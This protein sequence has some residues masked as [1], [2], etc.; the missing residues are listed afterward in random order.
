MKL[1]HRLTTIAA[2]ITTSAAA[3]TGT[4]A[5]A[6]DEAP[7]PVVNF[8]TTPN[9]PVTNNSGLSWEELTPGMEVIMDGGNC[10]AGFFAEDAETAE[11]VMI[12]AGHCAD[13]G[14][15]V[16]S[17]K[18]P[19]GLQKT[20]GTASAFTIP[21]DISS[22]GRLRDYATVPLDGSNRSVSPRIANAYDVVMVLK[23]EDLKEGMEL[24][25]FGTRTQETCG[26]FINLDQGFIYSTNFNKPGDSGGPVYVKLGGN[27]VALVG[28]VARGDDMGQLYTTPAANI[29]EHE[30]LLLNGEYGYLPEAGL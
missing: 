25:K 1:T 4:T 16:F 2:A 22:P 8:N 7:Q 18:S 13:Q 30:G 9:Q 19:D 17:W 20:L 27:Q 14:G 21:E 26:D 6:Q 3:F 11:T 10:T 28:I 24:C 15:E 5:L 29:L 23:P 12:T